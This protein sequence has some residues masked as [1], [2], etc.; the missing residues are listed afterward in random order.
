MGTGRGTGGDPGPGRWRSA[1]EERGYR[2]GVLDG[3]RRGVLGGYRRR[4]YRRGIQEAIQGKIGAG[5]HLRA[6]G[7]RRG[8]RGTGGG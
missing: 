1:P 2:R 7:Y 4:R 3:Y 8:I 5:A 6:G